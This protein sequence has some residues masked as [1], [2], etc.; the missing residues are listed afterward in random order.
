MKKTVSA[1]LAFLI[2]IFST[3]GIAQNYLQ[4]TLTGQYSP[5]QLVTFASSIPFNDA[6]ALINKVSEKTTG[7]KV[8][9]TVD[10]TDPVGVEI[11]GLYYEKALDIIVKYAGLIYERQNDMIVV[12]NSNAPPEVKKDASTYAPVDARD[13]KISAIFFDSDVLKARQMGINWQVLLSRNGLNLGGQL[14]DVTDAD[15]LTGGSSSTSS[16]SSTSTQ[17]FTG[18]Q[19]AAKSSFNLG[20]FSGNATALF[21]FLESENVGEVI[22]APNTTVR[23]G[24]EGTIQVGSDFSVKTKDFAGNTIEKFY[25]T[26]T[27]LKVTPHVYSEKGINYIILNINAERSTFQ[28]SDLTSVINKTA[29]STQV[30]MLNGEETVIG[31]LFINDE[32]TERT[33]VP[34]LKDLPW[35]VF[36]LRYIFGSDNITV[37]KRELVIL[38]K[39]ELIPTLEERLAGPQATNPLRDEIL[40]NREKIKYYKFNG[41]TN[42]DNN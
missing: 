28:V 32:K 23:D 22:T 40:K 30:I 33:G 14:G 34:F 20:D 42:T 4:K 1:I 3:P 5:D 21:Q 35:W 15:P 31:G 36:G 11:N 19:L 18:G 13:V 26:G 41:T 2:I 16:S 29:A 24:Q 27:I 25:P 9:S 39:A 17:K 38:I 7:I 12:K 6:I 10:R 8:V 37:E